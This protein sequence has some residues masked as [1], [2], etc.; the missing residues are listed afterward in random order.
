M[1]IAKVPALASAVQLAL[2]KHQITVIPYISEADAQKSASSAD[3][4][5]S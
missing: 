1:V 4:S 2:M 5:V 3:D